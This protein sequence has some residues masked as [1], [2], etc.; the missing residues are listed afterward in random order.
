VNAVPGNRAPGTIV[1]LLLAA[2]VLTLYGRTLHYGFVN[3]DDSAYVYENP[4]VQ[5][6]LTP[7]TIAWAFGIHGPSMWVPLT[8]LSHQAVTTAFGPRAPGAHHAVNV[9]LHTANV[10]LLF[11]VLR[12][13]T[14]LFWPSALAALCLAVHPIHVESVA[15]ITER[16]DVLC[17]CFWLLTLWAYERYAREGGARRYAQVCLGAALALMAKPLAVT[18]PAVLLLLDYWPLRRL[19]REGQG[20]GRVFALRVTEKLPLL[21]MAAFASI[22]TVLCQMSV[23]AIGDSTLYPLARRLANAAV[24]YIVYI[25][26]LVWPHNL[27]VFYSYP[28]D[29]EAARAVPAALALVLITLLVWMGARRRPYGVVGW[30]WYLGVLVPMI[31]LVQ[32]G[33][34][35]RADRYMYLPAIGLY[36][37]VAMGLRAWGM[38][39]RCRR[40]VAVTVSIAFAALWAQATWRQVGVW[41]SSTALF[42]HALR[43]TEGNYLAH[44]NLG[45]EYREAGRVADA[46]REFMASLA[47]KPDY[48]EAR[49]NLGVTLAMEGAYEPAVRALTDAIRIDPSRAKPHYNAGTAYLILNRPDYAEF[50]FRRAVEQAPEWPLARYN[51]GVALMRLSRWE[52]AGEAFEAALRLHPNYPDARTNL[53]LTRHRLSVEP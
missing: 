51:H 30:F 33:S 32:A 19:D 46:K 34:Q 49:S 12:R 9:L 29:I 24:S 27:T 35:A 21:A 14:G 4:R 13:L 40:A 3:Y 11:T 22:M 36:L 39:G 18:L 6:G 17:G 20:R 7:S 8:W 38:R 37:L 50:C 44:N 47:A 25:G 10:L 42:E 23:Q 2:V 48:V 31:G 16:K 5:N 53:S 26:D 43:V 41:S 28:A 52:E 45:L 1:C 15:W